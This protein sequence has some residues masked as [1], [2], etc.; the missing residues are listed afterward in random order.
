MK[1]FRRLA[2]V[3]TIAT[4]VLIFIGGL[5]RVSGAGLGCPDWPKCFG[6]WIP[7]FSKAD[8]P[9][10]LDPS[11]FNI[12]LAWIEYGNRLAGMITG[13]L[14]L[15]TAVLAFI[16]FRR[17]RR[18]LYPTL[19]AA[20]LTAY[21]GWQ[22][23]K[24]VASNL[25]SL[26]V[27]VHLLLALLIVS[28][29]MYVSQQTYFLESQTEERESRYPRQASL[30][31]VLLWL[32]GLAQI[33]LGTQVRTGV[34]AAVSAYPLW[35]DLQWLGQVGVPYDI[36]M[37]FGTLLAL[38]TWFVGISLLKMSDNASVLVKRTI[39]W[40][41]SLVALQLLLGFLLIAEGLKPVLQVFHLWAAGLFVGLTLILYFGVKQKASVVTGYARSFARVTMPVI[42]GVAVLALLAL[43][44]TSSA[45]HSRADIQVFDQVPEFHFVERSGRPFGVEQLKGKISVVDF[46][47]VNCHGPCPTMSATLAE[48]YRE[49]AHSDKLQFVSFTVDPDRDTLA[50]LNEYAAEFGVNDRRWSFVRGSATD[51]SDLCEKGF[52]VSGELPGMHSTKFI[53]VDANA[54]IRGYFDYDDPSHLKILNAHIRQLVRELP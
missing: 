3:S 25:Q 38:F 14:I 33:V 48:M 7:P 54:R 26:L 32:A 19:L 1:S 46:F 15:A 44:V 41:S 30:W 18:V 22:G 24:V 36:H 20:L 47:F 16:Y 9:N 43:F 52:L 34:E 8:I 35:S 2:F 23:G 11:T 13:F 6:R 5:V 39:W 10:G 37:I 40:L 53:L 12:T 49:Y 51:V 27:S 17:N 21:Q 31:V 4:Y 29:L 42:T 45:D 50:A 28:L